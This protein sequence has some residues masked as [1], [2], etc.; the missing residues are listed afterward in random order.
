MIEFGDLGHRRWGGIRREADAG[1]GEKIIRSEHVD[2]PFRQVRLGPDLT[3]TKGAVLQEFGP[4]ILP[5][6]EDDPAALLDRRDGVTLDLRPVD[7][8]AKAPTE[9][10][11]QDHQGSQAHPRDQPSPTRAIFRGVFYRDLA[12]HR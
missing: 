6:V 8:P 9:D 12:P 2:E 7:D 5:I 1:H 10:E 11:H 4:E 3:A